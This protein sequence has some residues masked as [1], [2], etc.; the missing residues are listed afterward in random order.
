MQRFL[1]SL[2]IS[3]LITATS[4]SQQSKLLGRERININD[5]WR[6]FRYTDKADSL[7]YDERPAVI[8]PNDNKVADT[9]ASETATSKSSEQTLKN[10]ILP[11]ANDFIKDETK[12]HQRP[13]GSP[14]KDFPFVQNN[15][16]DKSWELINLPHD[17]AINQN[18]YK[19]DNAI[20]GGGMSC[21]FWSCVRLL[22]SNSEKST[23]DAECNT[24][25]TKDIFIFSVIFPIS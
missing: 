14:G 18:F 25:Y 13:K 2:T 21:E 4:F 11:T 20:V 1:F 6:F 16:N 3:L 8:N 5:G 9:R 19:G 12:H 24:E 22:S 15:F 17:W 10:W 23:E 7:I